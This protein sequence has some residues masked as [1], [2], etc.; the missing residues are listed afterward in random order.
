MIDEHCLY[1]KVDYC[2]LNSSLPLVSSVCPIIKHRFPEEA[3]LLHKNMCHI[4][5]QVK[6]FMMQNVS[7]KSNLWSTQTIIVTFDFT[8]ICPCSIMHI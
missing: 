5:K 7:L 4:K 3:C 8:L 1:L 6:L 2:Q